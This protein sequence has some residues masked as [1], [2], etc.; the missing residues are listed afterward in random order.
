MKY[1]QVGVVNY[2]PRIHPQLSGLG[3]ADYSDPYE[4]GDVVPVIISF[5]KESLYKEHIRVE[6]IYWMENKIEGLKP[7]DPVIINWMSEE[8]YKIETDCRG[9]GIFES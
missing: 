3:T 2:N 4:L 7:G 5:V 6:Q 8:M 9:V 1:F